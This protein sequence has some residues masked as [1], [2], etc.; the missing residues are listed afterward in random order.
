VVIRRLALAAILA[1]VLSLA[2]AGETLR[3]VYTND[4]HARLD[5]LASIGEWIAA[6]R[7]IGDPVLVV[8]AGDA[9]QDFRVPLYAFWGAEWVLAWMNEVGYD[10]MAPGNHDFYVG[11]PVV[12]ALAQK[13]SFPILCA[14]LA[15]ADGTAPPF[16][17]STRLVV[18][19][20]DVLVIGLTALEFVPA[21]EMPWLRP[22]D[23]VTAL[24]W[25]VETAPGSPD[26]IVCLAHVPVREA[27][28]LAR[29]VPEIDLFVTG[30]SHETTQDPVAVGTTLIVQSGAFG[31]YVGQLVLD[32]R[33]DGVRV[34]DHQLLATE[35]RAGTD[36]G[37]GLSKL[38]SLALW[39]AAFLLVLL[40]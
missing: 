4:L 12:R 19:G 22:T 1:A 40:V 37:P 32:V 20:L 31:R 25:Q 26:L 10:A 39:I 38:A 9:W 29:A 17:G 15:P 6:A 24:R 7:E 21:L 30:H 34:V 3:V 14:N 28:V 18:G 8:D 16:P 2:A 27:E 36:L 23:P 35:E 33:H 5:R 11:W 13:A